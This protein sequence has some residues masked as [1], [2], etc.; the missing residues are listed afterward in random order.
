MKRL[1]LIAVGLTMLGA[2]LA[3]ADH[4]EAD[5]HP[6]YELRTYYTE[7]GKIDDLH[8]RFR[9][10]TI[11]LFAK[12]GIKNIGYWS[13]A[14]DPSTLIY[15]IAHKD[16]DAAKASWTAFGQDPEWQKVA[17]SSRANGPILTKI[18]S[19]YMTKTPYSP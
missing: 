9:D 11:G 6:L 10:H 14:E 15:L 5:E 8:A 18:D 7:E 12:H 13:P 16:A 19:V 4:H 3:R 1:L 17:K 2:G